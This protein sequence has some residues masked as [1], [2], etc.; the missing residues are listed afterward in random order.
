M[1]YVATMGCSSCA[2]IAIGGFKGSQIEINDSYKQS[3]TVPLSDG[4]TPAEFYSKILYPTEQK[5]GRSKDLPFQKLME[6]IDKT[7]LK[8]K[9]TILTINQSQFFSKDKYWDKE[10]KRW[11]FAL[12]HKTGNTIGETNYIYVRAPL[13]EQILEEEK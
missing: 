6:D 4:Y 11:G 13:S 10:F 12:V 2:T 9:F 5:L 7:S 3:G 8:N 1:A